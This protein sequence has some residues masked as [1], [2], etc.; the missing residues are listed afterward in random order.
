MY[1]HV[2]HDFSVRMCRLDQE[3]FVLKVRGS[4]SRI[5]QG[6][7]QQ[8]HDQLDNLRNHVSAIQQASPVVLYGSHA[9]PFYVA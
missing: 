6:G 4:R 9:V 3:S 8:L 2:T 5:V 1:N 7:L